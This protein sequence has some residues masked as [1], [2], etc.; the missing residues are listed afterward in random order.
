ML[1]GTDGII[2]RPLS[3]EANNSLSDHS[4]VKAACHLFEA[5]SARFKLQA[6]STDRELVTLLVEM[7]PETLVVFLQRA[8]DVPKLMSKTELS[9]DPE[10]VQTTRLAHRVSSGPMVDNARRSSRESF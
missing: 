7:Q 2:R 1:Q 3:D 4:A 8:N 6:Q 5:A 10:G 9:T